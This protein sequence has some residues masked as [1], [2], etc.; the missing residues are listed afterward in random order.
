MRTTKNNGANKANIVQLKNNRCSALK[1]PK[2]KFIQWD[3]ILKTFSHKELKEC[4][5][6]IIHA[7]LFFI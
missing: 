1:P 6:L 2:D 7:L 3:K 4:K 5:E